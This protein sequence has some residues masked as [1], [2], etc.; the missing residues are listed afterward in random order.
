MSGA[1]RAGGG[2]SSDAW[3]P[4]PG[5][6]AAG[7]PGGGPPETFRLAGYHGFTEVARGGDSIVYRARQDGLDRDVAIKAVAIEDPANR[8]RFERE[9]D[10]TVR[11]GRQHP[12]IITVL[13]TGTSSAGH[14]CIVM[15]F[16]DLG[17]LHDRLAAHG[18]LP[19]DEVVTAGTVVADALDFAHAHGV[20]HRDIKPQNILVLPTSYVL[21]DFGIARMADA[22]HTASLERFSYR[23]AS[24]QVL[25]GEPPTAADDVWSLGSTLF[26]LLDG[27]PPFAA[28]DPDDDTALA[29]L[30]R[31]RTAESRP[32]NRPDVAPELVRIVERCL[33]AQREDR[34]ADAATLRAALG[35]VRSEHRGWAPDSPG[36]PVHPAGDGRSSADPHPSGD[37]EP[38]GDADPPAAP[39]S[40]TPASSDP[41]AAVHAVPSLPPPQPTTP[42]PVAPSALAH[43]SDPGAG[44]QALSRTARA[45]SAFDADLDATGL[46]PSEPAHAE[47]AV[48]T[49]PGTP[50]EPRHGSR[51]WLTMVGFLAGALLLGTLG[52][53]LIAVLGSG[54]EPDPAASPPPTLVAEAV[55]TSTSAPVEDDALDPDLSDPAIAPQDVQLIDQGTSIRVSWTDPTG[56]NAFF[57]VVDV[58]DEAQPN[59]L[60]QVSQDQTQLTVEGID[61]GQAQVC[62]SVVGILANERD[63]FGASKPECVTR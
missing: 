42:G 43:L 14:A 38:G 53:A 40:S 51:R 2:T 56:G 63:R 15:D 8:A 59:A 49:E 28:D 26:T 6:T 27:R 7:T 33:S 22:G 4:Q 50:G 62:V 54:D 34:F 31:V 21:A 39:S 5:T 10:I 36:T 9:L 25:D 20:L 11:L 24:P 17:S 13:D 55:P 58:T 44:A 46:R 48:P 29:Y 45:G 32:L 30:R 18:P 47:P 52:G 57:V 1:Q 19:G 61:P 3:A 41:W 12:H 37:E 23:H 60:R 35:G 16:F